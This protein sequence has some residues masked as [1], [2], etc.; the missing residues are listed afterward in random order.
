MAHN[1]II[2]KP[3]YVSECWREVLAQLKPDFP[4]LEYLSQLYER[5]IPTNVKVINALRADT[6]L[7]VKESASS[8]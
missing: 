5:L 2:Q 7:M 1:E 6:L 4:S 8:I 3:Q